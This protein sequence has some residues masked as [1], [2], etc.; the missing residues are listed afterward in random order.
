MTA[1]ELGFE[2]AVDFYEIFGGLGYLADH[3]SQKLVRDMMGLKCLGGTKEQQKLIV[4]NE[5]Q[6]Q[7]AA[8]EKERAKENARVS[9]S[10][11]AA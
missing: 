7:V 1:V 2:A 9:E 6:Q 10:T 3:V 4:F 8:Q 11:K 5:L